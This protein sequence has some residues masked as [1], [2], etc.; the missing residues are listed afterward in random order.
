MERITEINEELF[1]HKASREFSMNGRHFLLGFIF[2]YSWIWMLS[3]SLIGVAALIIGITIDIRW[4]IVGLMVVLIVMPMLFAFLY[5]YYG[6]R[7]ECYVNTITHRIIFKP[8][9]INVNLIFHDKDSEDIH[10]R[11][12]FFAYSEMQPFEIGSKSVTIPFRKPKKG[13]LWIPADA[14]ENDEIL[15]HAL[16]YLDMQTSPNSIMA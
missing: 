5:Y 13:F 15:V 2:R 7:R 4:F 10:E 1:L 8:E 16:R 12:E 14:F 11:D 3:L 6:L 9:G